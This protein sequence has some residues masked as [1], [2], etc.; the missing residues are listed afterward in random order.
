MELSTIRMFL[1]GQRYS[2]AF[3]D[4]QSDFSTQTNSKA[5]ERLLAGNKWNS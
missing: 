3:F 1:L 2:S 5:W 4:L